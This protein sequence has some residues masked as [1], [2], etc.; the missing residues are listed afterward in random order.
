MKLGSSDISAVK[1]GSTDVSKVYIGSTEVWSSF[2]GLLDTYTGAAAAY[3]LR[4]LKSGVTNAIEVRIDTTGQPTYDIGFVNGELDVTT[5]E[6]YCTGGLDAYVTTWYDQSGNGN[7]ATQTSASAQPQIVSSG[8]VI[9][10]NGKPAV[11][12]DGSNDLLRSINTFAVGTSNRTYFHVLKA[13]T[14]TD[15]LYSYGDFSATGAYW[16]HASHS[17]VGVNGGNKFWANSP[18]TSQSL[19]VLQ[20]LGTNVTDVDFYLNSNLQTSTSSASAVINTA[21]TDLFIGNN[22]T[23]SYLNGVIQELV[24]YNSDQS[25]NR[26]GIETNIN[27]NYNM[28]WDGSQTS[29]LDTY[30]GSAAAYS[31]RALSSSYTGPLVEVRRASDN[32]TQDIYAKYD[33]SLNVDALESFC[34]GTNGFVTKWYDQSGNGRDATQTTASD[35]PQIVSSG[36]VITENGKPAVQFDGS[37]TILETT[38]LINPTIANPFVVSKKNNDNKY[39]LVFN[40]WEAGSTRRWYLGYIG[41]IFG[42]EPSD[43]GLEYVLRDSLGTSYSVKTNT[44]YLNQVLLSGVTDGSTMYL[45]ANNNSIG[46]TT[47]NGI[48]TSNQ[49]LFLG[50]GKGNSDLYLNGKLQEAIL[51]SSDQSSNRTGIETNINDFYSIY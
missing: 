27:A 16:S 36:S 20:S 26:T 38:T 35:Q 5:L 10:E 14:S 37:N 49:Y 2:T 6:G 17:V 13:N 47:H 29:L 34:S 32:A 48:T 50:G 40:Q 1:I 24:F 31:L 23:T 28:Y 7:D 44:E 9:T 46:N 33:G 43:N 18:Q 8:S 25:S 15:I 51:Y 21:T 3:S 42:S 19:S 45:F 30:S 41:S 12:F 22:T 4:Q 39:A 11:Q